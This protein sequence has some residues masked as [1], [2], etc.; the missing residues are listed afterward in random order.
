MVATKSNFDK[1]KRIYYLG[2]L[3]GG[4]FAFFARFISLSVPI[5]ALDK[6]DVATIISSRHTRIL[7]IAEVTSKIEIQTFWPAA[8]D[9]QTRDTRISR[10]R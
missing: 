4:V 5:A 2:I 7:F 6:A 1:K 3:I 9:F 8:C 10:E